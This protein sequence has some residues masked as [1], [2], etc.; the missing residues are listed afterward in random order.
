[1]LQ[2]RSQCML[3]VSLVVPY[4]SRLH[5]LISICLTMSC[6]LPPELRL[7]TGRWHRVRVISFTW[8]RRHRYAS[9]SAL[10][11]L[12]DSHRTLH[13]ETGSEWH[14]GIRKTWSI[15]L[16]FARLGRDQVSLA[17]ADACT[18]CG[19]YVCKCCMHSMWLIRSDWWKNTMLAA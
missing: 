11:N 9:Y 1:M 15:T 7:P 3:W 18:C 4:R 19:L 16:P 13:A 6:I 10:D 2:F 8:I 12:V 5:S 14:G 17:Y